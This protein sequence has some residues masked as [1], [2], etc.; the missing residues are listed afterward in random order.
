MRVE[1]V[2]MKVGSCTQCVPSLGDGN[3]EA[4]AEVVTGGGRLHGHGARRQRAQRIVVHQ[5]VDGV[6]VGTGFN[7]AEFMLTD[8]A[9]PDTRAIIL[10]HVHGQG[11]CAGIPRA[12]KAGVQ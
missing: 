6:D 10:N 3:A 7:G 2:A 9:E 5:M 1:F 8:V 4:E 12:D 11:G